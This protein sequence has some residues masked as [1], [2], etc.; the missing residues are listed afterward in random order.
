MKICLTSDWHIDATTAGK[1][2]FDELPG[3]LSHLAEA[4]PFDYL[5][6]LGD[7]FDPGSR[8]GPL[9]TREIAKAARFIDLRVAD[10]SVWIAGN[11]DIIEIDEPCSTVSFLPSFDS[12]SIRFADYPRFIEFNQGPILG[13]LCLPYVSRTYAKTDL[14]SASLD[15]AFAEA[16]RW[17]ARAPHPL[18]VIGHL[19]VPGAKMGSESYEMARGRDVDFPAHDVRELEPTFVA[20]GHYHEAQIVKLSGLDVIIPGS[21]HRFTFGERDDVDKGFTVIEL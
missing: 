15:L 3:Y 18:V 6:H 10:R 12:R 13:V 5:F 11:H 14:Y 17:K 2:R 4:G 1:S 9:Y 7:V 19:T 16:K 21:P 20:N 8:L